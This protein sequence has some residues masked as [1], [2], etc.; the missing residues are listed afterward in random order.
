MRIIVSWCFISLFLV[1]TSSLALNSLAKLPKISNR[2]SKIVIAGAGPAGIMAASQLVQAG[3]QNITVLEKSPKFLGSKVRTKRIGKTI[4]ETGPIQ[5]GIGHKNTNYWL[6][7]LGI[8]TFEPHNAFILRKGDRP[9]SHQ[10]IT[11]AQEFVPWGQRL[12]IAE[13]A[14]RFKQI[15][16]E[17]NELYPEL[18]DVPPGSIYTQ[19]FAS[20]CRKKNLPHFHD[21]YSIY[22]S[23]YGYGITSEIT[24][25]KVLRTF[26]NSFSLVYWLY[27]GM[28]LKMINEGF[29]ALMEGLVDHFGLADKI[30]YSQ[31]IL[32]IDRLSGKIQITT[33]TSQEEYDHLIVA[34][35]I[36][37]IY[38]SFGD[39]V[40]DDETKMYDNLH[41]SPY[42]VLVADVPNLPRGGFVLPEKFNRHGTL[43]MMSKN[44][45]D[46]DE[47]VLYVPQ[48][49][50]KR[51]VEILKNPQDLPSVRESID[52][53]R[54]NLQELGLEMTTVH[55]AV[56][57]NQ[58][59]PHFLDPRMYYICDSVQGKNN[60]F[61]VGTMCTPIDYV[62]QAFGHATKIVVENFEGDFVQ[63][64]QSL[65]G[66]A[67]WHFRAANRYTDEQINNSPSQW[68]LTFQELWR[69]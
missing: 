16:A 6:D 27:A 29:G 9:Q 2:F 46:G 40:S 23:A 32:N 42:H 62:D 44:S 57:W 68:A 39:I 43:Q 4:V 47:V 69:E 36:D 5:V 7:L 33:D 65:S 11:S 56:A 51:A 21:M 50:S 26:G 41:Y 67:N 55:D 64:E 24:T 48:L 1:S 18:K 59:N 17:F 61:Y 13:E 49:S 8:Q 45:L 28:N 31:N 25:F 63:P 35:P 38:A 3:Y 52:A 22:T 54:Q 37:K 30:K 19:P 10:I 14:L 60:T 53:A 20:F 66:V 58:Y 15:M 12:E 34:C